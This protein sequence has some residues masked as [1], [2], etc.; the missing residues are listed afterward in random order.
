MW[1][2]HLEEYLGSFPLGSHTVDLFL[3]LSHISFLPFA[4]IQKYIVLY[5]DTG[6]QPSDSIQELMD[7]V[8]KHTTFVLEPGSGSGDQMQKQCSHWGDA[9]TEAAITESVDST[10]HSQSAYC[11]GDIC[12]SLY[13]LQM[14]L[15]A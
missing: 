2:I 8:S 15:G 3:T 7:P 1:R 12:F 9:V 6:F 10:Q 14:A 13:K 5:M 11:L 4:V